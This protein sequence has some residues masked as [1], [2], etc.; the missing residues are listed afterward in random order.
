VSTTQADAAILAQVAQRFDDVHQY[1]Q[2]N[3]TRLRAEVEG[4]RGDWQGSGA[5]TFNLVTQAW[6]EQQDRLLVTLKDTADAVRNSGVY[7]TAV[8]DSASDRFKGTVDLTALDGHH[9]GGGR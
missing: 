2:D 3:L 8:D 4:V 7:Y 1:L 5:N 9:G 6:S